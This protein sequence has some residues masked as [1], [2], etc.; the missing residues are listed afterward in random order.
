MTN[1]EVIAALKIVA[2]T[3][4]VKDISKEDLQSLRD[5]N[6]V[7]PVEDEKT[8]KISYALTKKGR[9]MFKANSK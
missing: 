3:G 2:E 7:T 8:K 9:V 4:K 6:L 1:E 5:Y